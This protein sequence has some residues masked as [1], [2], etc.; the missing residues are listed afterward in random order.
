VREAQGAT[1][2]ETARELWHQ[3]QE[4]QYEE[5][6]Y[7]VWANLE[8]L[9]AVGNHVKGVV[10]SAWFNLGGWNYRDVWLDV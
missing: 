2:E 5:G 7:I 9:D 3:V 8:L 4:T 6:G 10:P 1:D